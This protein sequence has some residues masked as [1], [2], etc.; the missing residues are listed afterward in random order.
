MSTEPEKPATIT[1]LQAV[2]QALHEAMEADER[3]LVFGEDVGGPQGGGVFKTSVGLTEKFG[4]ARCRSTPIAEQAIIGAAVGAAIAGMRPV[5]E[6]MLMNF[7]TVAMDQIVNHAAKLRFMSGGQT[8]VPL[9]IRTVGGGGRGNGGQ[10]ADSLEAWFAHVPGLKVVAASNPADAKGLLLSCIEDD[11]PCIVID[12]IMGFQQKGPAPPPGYRTPLGKAA[13][14][15]GGK[16]AT[17]VSYGKAVNDALAVAEKMAA[18]GISVEVVDLR[19]IA[20]FDEET[21][22][23]SVAKTRRAVVLHEAVKAFGVGA[24]ISSRIHEELF[25]DLRAPVARVG[26]K[27]APVPFAPPLEKAFLFSQADIEA[28]VNKTLGN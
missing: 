7:I 6:I 19:T 12:H 5:A 14:A 27:Y 23:N 11:N 20:P 13:I 9:T 4:E 15:R 17:I 28:A 21:V 10:H 18:D 22:L 3:V 8:S 2:N 26:S 24:E 25:S 1:Y 16:D